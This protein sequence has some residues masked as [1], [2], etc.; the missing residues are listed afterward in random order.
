MPEKNDWHTEKVIYTL[1]RF[2]QNKDIV[3]ICSKLKNE[4]TCVIYSYQ[5]ECLPWLYKDVNVI[6]NCC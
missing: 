4:W 6:L 1:W 5:T 2:G 3:K